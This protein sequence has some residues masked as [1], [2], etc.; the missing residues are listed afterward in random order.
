MIRKARISDIK[1]IHASLSY[2]ASK[3]LL[4]SRSLSELY[5]QIRDFA[6]HEEDDGTISGFVALHIVWDDLAEI[7]SLAVNEQFHKKGIGRALVQHSISEAI[8]LGLYRIFTL[9]Y[10]PVFFQKLGFSMID[11]S[12]LPHKVWA[13]CVK[14][15]KFPDCDESCLILEL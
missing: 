6:V 8:T 2:F 11:K 12:K 9:T 13:D 14:C 5:D 7:R 10:Q 3:G 15:P 1:T 4:L